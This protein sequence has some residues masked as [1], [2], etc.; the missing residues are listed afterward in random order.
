M[1]LG[2]TTPLLLVGLGAALVPLLVH[3]L[4]RRPPLPTA[5]PALVL[6]LDPARR[7]ARRRRLREWL[8]LAVR[9]ALLMAV[10]VALAGPYCN[11]AV[12]VPSTAGRHQAAVIVMDDS[13]SMRYRHDGRRLFDVARD[14]A[15]A[16]L[17]VL[18]SSAPA[19]L[20]TVTGRG[21]QVRE[22]SLDRARLRGVLAAMKPTFLRGDGADALARAQ[23]LL[24]EARRGTPR[25]IYVLSDLTRQGLAL[26]DGG[27]ERGT[28]LQVLD[29][30]P[31]AL[32]NR[33]VVQIR[34]QTAAVAAPGTLR[35]RVGLRNSTARER[36][37]AVRLEAAGKVVGRRS[38][39]VPS[40]TTAQ[41]VIPVTLK[42][43]PPGSRFLEAVVS[44]TDGLADDDRRFMALGAARRLRIL[45]VDGDPRETRHEDELFYIE[46]ALRSLLDPARLTLQV[47]AGEDLDGL[48]FGRQDLVVL[49][50][51][52][53]F[54][55]GT[56]KRLGGF[57]RRGGALWVA[58]GDQVRADAYNQTLASLLPGRLRSFRTGGAAGPAGPPARLALLEA[59]PVLRSAL[60]DPAARRALMAARVR[61]YALLRDLRGTV[62]LRLQSGAPLLVSQTVG[63]GR[64]LLMTTTLDRDWT[65]LVHRPAFLPLLRGVLQLLTGHGERTASSHLRVGRPVTLRAKPG[66]VLYVQPPG[67]ALRRL[68][69]A[70]EDG[71]VIFVHTDQPGP[72]RVFAAGA[73]RAQRAPTFALSGLSLASVARPSGLPGLSGLRERPGLA[74]AVVTDPAESDLRRLER[75]PGQP[76]AF[77]AGVGGTASASVRDDLTALFALLCLLLLLAEALLAARFGQWRRRAS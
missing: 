49:A 31:K 73:G 36:E 12:L 22:L 27:V 61:R 30:A 62:L 53:A 18:P 68:P 3:L 54:S 65:D 76:G 25:A 7:R 59:A 17:S 35:V 39:R 66:E 51:V 56:V 33:A 37:L 48:T 14:R 45:L 43:L 20:I 29:V 13:L 21:P 75:A 47:V 32:P 69:P 38:V 2:F 71:T 77:G 46:S 8:L 15:R 34:L 24:S 9:M 70:G 10:A 1:N 52:G 4:R 72:Y 42:S 6:L 58:L 67:G 74:F 41:A 63:A 55:R 5:F 57:V 44:G 60:E 40:H 64:V 11:R 19:A 26:P 16:L 23:R 50:N 28:A